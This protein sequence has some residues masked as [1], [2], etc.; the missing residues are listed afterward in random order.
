MSNSPSLLELQRA[1]HRAIV[2]EDDAALVGAIAT[3]ALAIP[4]AI[5]IYR[6]TVRWTLTRA[7]CLSYPAVNRLVGTEFFEGA[8]DAFLQRHWPVSACL[9]DFGGDF[10]A[11]LESFAPAAELSYLPDVA[12]LEWAV[13]QALHAP[14]ATALELER[15]QQLNDVQRG[16]VCFVAHPSLRL[17]A[18]QTPA[19]SIW[20]AV[21]ERDE[22]KL[23]SID[24]TVGPAW[25]VVQRA[26][27]GGAEVSSV[28]ESEWRLLEALS[29]GVR[30]EQALL[31]FCDASPGVDIDHA[32]AQLLAL[33]RFTDFFL[34]RSPV[35][36]G[37]PCACG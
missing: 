37:A 3:D 17:V 28:P 30:L 5:A 18:V 33:G 9:N 7:L 8:V 26:P 12:Q 16:A 20:R 15:L 14:E 2:C 25:L 23:T 13:H 24:T 6:N 32:L 21:L 1:L 4:N 34:E 22:Q 10:A 29:S 36:S 19:D 35:D 11:F 31:S 27:D